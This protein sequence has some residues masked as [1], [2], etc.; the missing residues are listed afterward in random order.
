MR[1][2]IRDATSQEL[3]KSSL[4]NLVSSHVIQVFL[5]RL[6]IVCLFLFIFCFEMWTNALFLIHPLPSEVLPFEKRKGEMRTKIRDATSQEL[7]KS[8][9]Q[10]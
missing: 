10:I 1:T 3:A 6:H 4:E 7:A 2:K 9:L 5:I 8:S